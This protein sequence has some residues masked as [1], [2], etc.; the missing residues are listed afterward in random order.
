MTCTSVEPTP[1]GSTVGLAPSIG[2][3]YVIRDFACGDEGVE[4]PHTHL[5]FM[6]VNG[7]GSRGFV[8]H[9]FTL[10]QAGRAG[11]L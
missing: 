10:R 3:A 2:G 11:P 8:G 5:V 1:S 6:Y 4:A 7:Q 9:P